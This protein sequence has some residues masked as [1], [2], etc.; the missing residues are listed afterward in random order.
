MDNFT[1]IDEGV[2]V[3]DD[4]LLSVVFNIISKDVVIRSILNMVDDHAAKKAKVARFVYPRKTRE[5]LWD[6][7]RGKRITGCRDD[8]AS[9]GVNLYFRVQSEFRADFRVPLTL[10]WS[11]RRRIF[12]LLVTR[13]RLFQTSLKY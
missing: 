12:L 9:G 1:D 10:S 4:E 5:E 6:T 3:K 13:E 8:I 2:Y 11:V 7:V